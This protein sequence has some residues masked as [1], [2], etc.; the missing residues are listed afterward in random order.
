MTDRELL[1]QAYD[2]MMGSER[3]LTDEMFESLKALKNRLAE[4][5]YIDR[6]LWKFHPMTGEPL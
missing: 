2:A 5:E 3:D 1:Q 4:F 6:R